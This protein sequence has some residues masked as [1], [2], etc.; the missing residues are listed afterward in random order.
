MEYGY[1]YIPA[2]VIFALPIIYGLIHGRSEERKARIRAYY[3]VTERC[4][5][6]LD[7]KTAEPVYNYIQDYRLA[8]ESVEPLLQEKERAHYHADIEELEDYLHDIEQEHWRK[9]AQPHLQSFMDCY[10]SLQHESFTSQ[11]AEQ[12]KKKC[13]REWQAFYGVPLD[14]YHTRIL[15][16]RFFKETL[17]DDFDECMND[18]YKLERKL[19]SFIQANSP[20][21]TSARVGSSRTASRADSSRPASGT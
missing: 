15:P 4:N 11:K 18:H 12:L 2:L 14:D 19:N 21:G 17:A 7:M 1:L 20:A 16:K 5:R 6:V 8:Y 9:R 10:D 13:I 3:K